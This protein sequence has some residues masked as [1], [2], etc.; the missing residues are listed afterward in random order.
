ML[1]SGEGASIDTFLLFQLFAILICSFSMVF[2]II[3][4]T[5]HI[6]KSLAFNIFSKIKLGVFLFYFL[7]NLENKWGSRIP[8]EA[9]MPQLGSWVQGLDTIHA[10]LSQPWLGSL[11]TTTSYFKWKSGENVR[12]CHKHPQM[13]ACCVAILALEQDHRHNGHRHHLKGMWR[14]VPPIGLQPSRTG[15]FLHHVCVQ[16]SERGCVH[17]AYISLFSP[18]TFHCIVSFR[19]PISTI[20]NALHSCMT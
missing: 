3:L 13:I 1:A 15:G 20:Q 18:K 4:T 10:S 9:P 5:F 12:K 14:Q 11:S 6:F 7:V 16:W 8:P 17:V 19:S 2:K